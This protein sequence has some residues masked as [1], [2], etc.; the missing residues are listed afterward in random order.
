MQMRRL[1]DDVREIEAFESSAGVPQEESFLAA[2]RGESEV[3]AYA[4]LCSD[5]NG[6]AASVEET[7][8]GT[9]PR[10]ESPCISYETPRVLLDLGLEDRPITFG[11]GHIVK[12]LEPFDEGRHRHGLTVEQVRRIGMRL[13]DPC[14]VMRIENEGAPG[15][16]VLLPELG[17]LDRP[18]YAPIKLD[19]KSIL[20]YQSGA[21]DAYHVL[22]VYGMYELFTEP[23][24]LRAAC[25]GRGG[26]G[27]ERVIRSQ[28]DRALM[29]G[30]LLYVNS[31]LLAETAEK[32]GYAV[33]SAYE[34]L[35]GQLSA[36][37]CARAWLERVG[38]GRG[39]TR[40]P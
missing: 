39:R 10:Y 17:P 40:R 28:L 31:G 9:I 3:R 32:A 11:Q 1:E 24:R 38:R 37:D 8:D 20:P 22:S 6:F 19:A 34:H 14:A 2:S 18:L 4:T 13:L 16:A 26:L 36:A 27:E 33:P 29:R 7:L 5:W 35:E 15:I 12:A 23:D 30:D 25:A 21:R